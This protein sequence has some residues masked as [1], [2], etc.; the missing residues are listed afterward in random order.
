MEATL[1]GDAACVRL[2]IEAAADVSVQGGV[3][4]QKFACE[5]RKVSEKR[6]A[7][8][9]AAM[10]ASVETVHMLLEAGAAIDQLDALGCTPLRLAIEGNDG[11]D[12]ADDDDD[13]H[14][15]RVTR[16]VSALLGARANPE[17]SIER[18]KRLPTPLHLAAARG[19]A[20]VTAMLLE[21]GA[22]PNRVSAAEAPS[23]LHL[24][25]RGRQPGFSQ[26]VVAL[27]QARADVNATTA[28]GVTPAAMAQR[29]KVPEATV[30]ALEQAQHVAASPRQCADEALSSRDS[31]LIL[32]T[33]LGSVEMRLRADAAP[34]TVE[35]FVALVEAGTFNGC[36][37]YRSDIVIQFGLRRPDGT[38]ATNPRPPLGVNETASYRTLSNVRGTVAIAHHDVPDCGN[39]EIFINLQSNA[40]LDTVGGGYCV[41]AQVASAESLATLDS[42][43][44]AVKEG[45]RPVIHSIAPPAHD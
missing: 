28:A 5:T 24:A 30:A 37:F 20:S 18:G 7:L 10:M 6:S 29:N 45:Q 42:I 41:F 39:D 4:W 33:D 13:E 17:P 11:L 31:L 8:H 44:A 34:K 21:A 27:L 43:A 16:V 19:D 12:A 15:E 3:G 38:E 26:V 32:R 1:S 23:P 35:H 36:C 2:L 22:D 40:E 14:G 25:S 9:L